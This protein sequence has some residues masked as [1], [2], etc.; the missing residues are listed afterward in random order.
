MM[1]AEIL[2]VHVNATNGYATILLGSPEREDRVLPIIIGLPEAQAIVTAL[3][4]VTPPRPGTHDL[5]VD[6]MRTAESELGQ[7]AVTELVDG[8]FHAEL[9]LEMT[10]GSQRISSRPS[11]G[12]ALAVRVGAPIVVASEVFDVAAVEIDRESDEPFTEE[13]VDEIVSEFQE[14]LETAQPSDFDTGE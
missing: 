11:D 12:I 9:S 13:E 10:T 5:M 1:P 2:G 7:V 4:G 8:T 14:F 6:V 3:A